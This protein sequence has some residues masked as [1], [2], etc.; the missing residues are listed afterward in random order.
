MWN[1]PAVLDRL[2]RV[3][4]IVTL[5]FVALFFGRMGLAEWGRIG[6]IEVFGANQ[7]QT[8]RAVPQVVSRLSGDFFSLDVERVKAEFAALPWVH[9]VEVVRLW[10]ARLRIVLEEHVPAAA[11]ND[12]AVMDRYGEI[13]PAR[14]WVGLPKIYAPEGMEIEVARRFGEFAVRLKPAGWQV[15]R[16]EVNR[17]E[18]W[19]LALNNGLVLVLG[20]DQLLERLD[21]FLAFYP[22][23]QA[24]AP[25]KQGPAAFKRIDLRY[26]NGFAVRVAAS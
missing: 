23:A 25:T 14:P 21:R 24:L 2:T 16:I 10:P 1:N 11:W 7:P 13:Y 17:R 5:L 19:Q 9:K 12:M 15:E 18:S 8:V 6:R 20:R 26:P 3:I 4:L 22:Q